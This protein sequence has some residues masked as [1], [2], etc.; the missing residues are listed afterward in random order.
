[1]DGRNTLNINGH[2]YVTTV[3]CLGKQ[4][5]VLGRRGS[6]TFDN[7]S[8]PILE[9]LRLE[10]SSYINEYTPFL[11]ISLCLPIVTTSNFAQR[12]SISRDYLT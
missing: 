12:R 10:D 7:D 4:F 6:M 5:Q 11:P 2:N 9:P 8:Y 1:M 3:T